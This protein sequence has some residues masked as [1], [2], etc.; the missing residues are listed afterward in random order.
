MLNGML[1][2][3]AGADHKFLCDH[4]VD[5]RI[6]MP[7]TSYVV[8]AWEALC[9]MKSRKME[10][11]P[12]VFEDVQIRQAVTAEEG[13]KVALAVLIAPDNRFCVSL[14]FSSPCSCAWLPE[15]SG[16]MTQP[17]SFQQQCMG[18]AHLQE[19]SNAWH[20][21][22]GPSMMMVLLC[23]SSVAKAAPYPC[24]IMSRGVPLQVLHS[25]D[26]ICEGTI[27]MQA[28]PAKVEE[29]KEGTV[30]APV[31]AAEEPVAAQ[32]VPTAGVT[33]SVAVISVS[34]CFPESVPKCFSKRWLCPQSMFKSHSQRR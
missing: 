17:A 12:V 16:S 28:E 14:H 8:T 9:S 22:R 24:R 31:P 26:L 4:V 1:H 2:L 27:K 32:A 5:G 25:G 15:A 20:N 29:P 3:R 6:L 30:A 33:A 34:P 7:A 10:E 19:V 18:I 23:I 21:L 13:Q 11:T